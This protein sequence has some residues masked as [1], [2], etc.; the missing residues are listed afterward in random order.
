MENLFSES[1][2][3]VIVLFALMNPFSLLGIYLPLTNRFSSKDRRKILIVM[4]VAINIILFS[5]LFFGL[6]ILGFFGVDIAG[7]TTAGGVIIFLIGLSMIR[8]KHEDEHKHGNNLDDRPQDQSPTSVAVVPLAIPILAGPGTIS[9]VINLSHTY[10]SGTGDVAIS[11]G[12]II[13]LGIVFTVFFFGT[14]ILSILGK[15]GLNIVTR[16]MGLFL[17]AIA[18]DMLAK[19]LIGLFPALT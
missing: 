13:V 17:M 3:A 14:S 11:L 6:E 16:I 7:F 8:A 4:I 1:V 15:T 18:F 19:G 5:F 2:N 12:I 10:N 9:T